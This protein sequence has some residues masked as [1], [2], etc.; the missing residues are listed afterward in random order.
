M[1]IRFSSL[2]II[3]CSLLSLGVQA[4]GQQGSALGLW[5]WTENQH[6]AYEYIGALPF[7]ALDEHGKDSQLPEDP[8]FLLGNH[9]ITL[10]THVS[11]IY[12]L[13]TA[14]RVW[15]RMNASSDRPNYG[16]NSASI[17]VD[18]QQ[19]SLVGIKSIAANPRLCRR[20]FGVGF[21]RYDYQLPQDIT[22]KRV[23]TVAP[24]QTVGEG[25]PSFLITVTIT[26]NSQRQHHIVYSEVMPVN[27]QPMWFQQ[28][29]RAQLN[30]VYTAAPKAQTDIHNATVAVRARQQH[31]LVVS[32]PDQATYYETLPPSVSIAST[33]VVSNSHNQLSATDTLTLNPS[34]SKTIKVAIGFGEQRPALNLPDEQAWR[35]VLPDLSHET[36]S[37]MRSEMLWNAYFV[38]ASA[39]YSDYFHETFIPQGSVYSYHYGENAANRD[40][41]Q[42]LLPAIY[43]NPALAR[44]ALRYVLKQTR[45]NGQITRWNVGYG[46]APPTIYKES[47]QQLYMFMAV[48]EYLRVT[49]DYKFL[50]DTII[51]Y[52]AEAHIKSTVLQLLQQQF[53]YLRDEI[54]RGENGLIKLQNSDWSDSFLHKYSPNV[55][56]WT[57]ESQLNTAM[58]MAVLPSFI[59]QLQGHASQQFLKALNEYTGEITTAMLR[60]LGDRPFAARAYLDKDHKFGLDDVCL[61]PQ[62]FLLL[63]PALSPERKRQISDYVGSRLEAP[64]LIGIRTRQR[65]LWSSHGDGEDGGIWFALEYPYLL[66]VA[67]IDTGQAW[68][69]MRKLSFH[70]FARCYPKYWIGQWTAP[71]EINSSLYRPGLYTQWAPV[72]NPRQGFQGLCSHPHTWPLYCYYKLKETTKTLKK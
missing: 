65:P 37:E 16:Q 55:F 31:F 8:Y 10:I 67:T 26:N 71:D 47:D 19:H 4:K 36:D 18:G 17:D 38:E 27:F 64:E 52:P 66:G 69:L 25:S 28:T 2:L 59:Q 21:A 29:D 3:L 41:L 44:S 15:A 1:S 20:R 62:G 39:K 32:N 40:H 54:G 14:K 7:V 12:Q 57:A 23:L 45:P 48:A 6:P 61:E 22:V 9:R 5:Y 58:A 43:T 34:E 11:G 49:H 50:S 30:Y 56:N 24:S 51:C 63:S 53:I 35:N 13:I 68:R 72:P 46:Y 70:N 42:A 33:A 60:D